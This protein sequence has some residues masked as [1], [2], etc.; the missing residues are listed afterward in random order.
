MES[1]LRIG[2][3]SSSLQHGVKPTKQIS[4]KMIQSSRKVI[5]KL[6][7]TISGVNELR[8]VQITIQKYW[9]VFEL[10]RGVDHPSK[11]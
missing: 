5:Y 11:T 1:R 8:V 7:Y 2:K 10:E 6:Q 3:T 9:L 4:N